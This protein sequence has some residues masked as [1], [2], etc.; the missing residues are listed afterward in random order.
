MACN[1][2]WS[3]AVRVHDSQAYTKMVV[4]RERIRHILEP[5]E[6]LLSFQTGFNL[7]NAVVICAILDSISGLEPSVKRNG[8]QVLVDCDCLMLLSV[9]F[10]LFVDA[11]GAV[12]HQLD[13]FGT[14]L[15]AAGCG[16]FV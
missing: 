7:V 11:A 8:S 10:D 16:G 5:R 3:T 12:C 6:K 1:L 14:D 2:L 4:T 13:L 9:Y 15:H